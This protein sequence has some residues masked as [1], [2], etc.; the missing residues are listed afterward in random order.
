MSRLRTN[1]GFLLFL[2][3]IVFGAALVF[4]PPWVAQQIE[5]ASKLGAT[6]FYI[7][8]TVVVLGAVVLLGA[9]GSIVWRLWQ[10]TRRKQADRVQHAKNPSQ[11]TRGEREQELAEN[12]L[13]ADDLRGELPQIQ[14]LRE[15]LAALSG[16]IEE[17]RASQTLEIVAFGSISSGKSSLL[18]AIAGRDVFQTDAKGGTTVARNEIPWPGL[19]QVVLVDTP[20]LGEVDGTERGVVSA[21]AAKE[22]DIVLMVVDGPLRDWEHRLLQQLAGM[23]KRTIICLN[24][25]DWFPE[26]DLA[27][28]LDQL[29][30]QVSGLV[31]RDDVL[32]VRSQMTKRKRVRV[33][34]DG[35]EREELVDV[36]LDIASL[37]NRMLQVIRRDGHDLILANLLL[38]SRGLVQEAR[39]RVQET[40]DQRAWETVDRYMWGAAGAAALSP[41]PVLDLAAGIAIST[42]MVVDL[43]HVYRQDVDLQAAV[44]LLGQLTKQLLAI[45]GVTAIGPAVATAIASLLK[46]VPGVGTLAGGVLQGIVQALITRWIGAVFIQYFRNEMQ[47]SEAG[48]ANIARQEWERLTTLSEL[49]RLVQTARSKLT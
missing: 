47:T 14:S 12:L 6:G 23:E 40:L 34:A 25:A 29:R 5:T 16:K 37:A 22:A 15:Q 4:L 35:E 31:Q 39:R 41:F 19:D 43:G 46:T 44:T 7:Y 24:K 20:G 17:K 27:R 49:R 48:L 42:K 18:N 33:L 30:D 11:L 28:L 38:Q 9:T 13:A 36:P 21:D 3:L 2:I 1:T 32:A 10:R 8:V 45:L 26:R